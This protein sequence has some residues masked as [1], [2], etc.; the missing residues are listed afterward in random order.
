M[1]STTDEILGKIKV[2]IKYVLLFYS[3][4]KIG[5]YFTFVQSSEIRE[6][7]TFIEKRVFPCFEIR[8]S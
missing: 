1:P 5:I 6:W 7:T 4:L 2:T 8:Q 3:E